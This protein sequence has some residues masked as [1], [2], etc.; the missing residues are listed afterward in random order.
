MKK[1][2]IALL[3]ALIGLWAVSLPGVAFS[4]DIPVSATVPTQSPEVTIAIK[5]LT[6]PGQDPGTSGTPV[7]EM[8]FNPLT[9]LL[10]GGADAGVW[11][12]QKYFCVFIYTSSWG[13]RYEVKS[14]CAGFSN[15][16]G[17]SLP[18]GSVGFVPGYIG[19]DRWI[20]DDILSAQDNDDDPPGD[21]G[22]PGPAIT[23]GV[24]VFKSIYV[25]EPEATNRILR[26]FYSIPP[27]ETG[28]ALAFPDQ[29]PIPL[30]Q[31]GGSYTGTVTITISA[32]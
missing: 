26:A 32:L 21:L 2:N 18:A 14:S 4:A 30:N 10:D 8:N 9:H 6:S 20:G 29:T 27:F 7:L 24:D 28:G 1:F 22:T 15:G 23:G 3:L 19:A 17:N 25:S 5:E 12:S 31:P 11:Y 16:L 13:N